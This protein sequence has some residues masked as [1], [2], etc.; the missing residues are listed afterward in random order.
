MAPLVSKTALRKSDLD[1]DTLTLFNQLIENHA[2]VL[3]YL[4]GLSG[5]ITLSN[6]LDLNGNK[7][8]N[9]G[10]AESESDVVTQA[11]ASRNYGPTALA[12]AFN[13]LG[14]QTLQTYRQ[15]SNPNQREKYSSFLN[16]IPSTPPSS[17]T[18]IV[19]FGTVSGGTVVTT[20]TAGF[21]QKVDSTQTPYASRTDTLALPS[22]HPISSLTRTSN[23]VTA[24]LSSPQ[25]TQV[26][27]GITIVGATD[28]SFDGTFVILTVISTSSFTYYQGGVNAV[29]SA[30][31]NVEIGGVYYYTLSAGQSVLGLVTGNG[32]SDTTSDRVAASQDGTTI[33]AV[34]ATNGSG[35]DS[36]NSAA[37]AS[38]LVTGSNI[39]VI[40]RL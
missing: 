18:S 19:T 38:P 12:P 1:D 13:A 10:A 24:V 28:P 21:H 14:K 8:T 31:G 35:G 6:H 22:S 29:S 34:V 5:P 30:G 11:F 3:N 27:E 36:V 33:I 39:A 16:D 15:L 17:N 32:A 37:G 26:G 40:R 9:V 2:D 4:L 23:I 20:V 7:I 25:S